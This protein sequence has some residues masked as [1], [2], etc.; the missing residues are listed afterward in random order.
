MPTS[1]L[2]HRQFD[3]F[4]QSFF[5]ESFKHALEHGYAQG[6]IDANLGPAYITIAKILYKLLN[7]SPEDILIFLNRISFLGIVFCLYFVSYCMLTR[8]KHFQT[9]GKCILLSSIYALSFAALTPF[10]GF[11]DIA[12]THFPAAFFLGL[13]FVI[14]SFLDSKGRRNGFLLMFLYGIA[15]GVYSQIRMHDSL[16]LIIAFVS[17]ILAA[18]VVLLKSRNTD[19]LIRLGLGTL[20]GVLGWSCISWVICLDNSLS[21]MP[22]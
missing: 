5:L 16:I 19:R 14:L 15:I 21:S 20:A 8:S 9:R 22:F 12:W 7:M 11:S 17:W 10:V 18:G 13:S 2:G 4:D 3:W 6:V 1:G